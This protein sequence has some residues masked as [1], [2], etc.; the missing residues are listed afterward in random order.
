MEW[1]TWIE[2]AVFQIRMAHRLARITVALA[3]S[4]ELDE[5]MAGAVRN[6]LRS[7]SRDMV[8]EQGLNPVLKSWC[9][10][11]LTD[12]HSPPTHETAQRLQPLDD[13]IRADFADQLFERLEAWLDDVRPEVAGDSGSF[14]QDALTPEMLFGTGG[15]G[16]A[17]SESSA[18]TWGRQ[19]EEHLPVRWDVRVANWRRWVGILADLRNIRSS[20]LLSGLTDA[21]T[22]GEGNRSMV[23]ALLARMIPGRAAP[24]EESSAP[25][26]VTSWF[27]GTVVGYN[28]A[29]PWPPLVAWEMITFLERFV[30]ADIWKRVKSLL[31]PRTSTTKVTAG[32]LL[33]D[34]TDETKAF[35]EFLAT[36]A[37]GCGGLPALPDQGLAH[38]LNGLFPRNSGIHLRVESSPGGG[39]H[40]EIP[41]ASLHWDVS[42]SATGP[43]GRERIAII[44]IQPE[45]G[46]KTSGWRDAMTVRRGMWCTPQ[47]GGMN[48]LRSILNRLQGIVAD[49]DPW[50]GYG[51][52]FLTEDMAGAA[53]ID[54]WFLHGPE[55]DRKQRFRIFCENWFR[56]SM[57]REPEEAV[58]ARDVL[59]RVLR[60]FGVKVALV[61]GHSDSA[62]TERLVPSTA[63]SAARIGTR[64]LHVEVN[65]KK[66]ELTVSPV[67]LPVGPGESASLETLFRL[68]PFVRESRKQLPFLKAWREFDSAL[69]CVFAEPQIG[70]PAGER[71][72]LEHLSRFAIELFRTWVGEQSWFER[73]DP[74]G[75]PP[76]EPCDVE[77]LAALCRLMVQ[78]HPEIAD[79]FPFPV[80][81][82]SLLPDWQALANSQLRE[83]AGHESRLNAVVIDWDFSAAPGEIVRLST[84]SAAG[85]GQRFRLQI[86]VG[87]DTAWLAPWIALLEAAPLR[88]SSPLSALAREIRHIPFRV[89]GRKNSLLG[90]DPP[91]ASW[92][93]FEQ[94][95]QR[96]TDACDSRDREWFDRT[97][98][99]VVAGHCDSPDERWL[100][101]LLR[102]RLVPCWPP[103]IEDAAGRLSPESC[104]QKES[105]ANWTFDG[106]VPRGDLIPSASNRFAVTPEYARGQLS[107]GPRQ[108]GTLMDLAFRLVA[109]CGTCP[110][111]ADA[112]ERLA[113]ATLEAELGE[114]RLDP[115]SATRLLRTALAAPPEGTSTHDL[116]T[117]EWTL[118][119]WCTHA[120]C[121]LLPAALDGAYEEGPRARGTLAVCFDASPRGS[122]RILRYG[123]ARLDTDG[124]RTTLA[125]PELFRSAGSEPVGLAELRRML[126]AGGPAMAGLHR[127]LDDWPSAALDR[128]L[129]RA[130]IQMYVEMWTTDATRTAVAEP[131]YALE[132]LLAENWKIVRFEPQQTVEFP[133][134]WLENVSP[135]PAVR[136]I[137]RSIVRPGLRAGQQLKLQ[138]IV[139]AE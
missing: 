85:E 24:I 124:S 68:Q 134:E 123:L 117:I 129:E 82:D 39:A 1:P 35:L 94:S 56:L 70:Q 47:T 136:G 93:E 107:L 26:S 122:L 2:E 137:I 110:A 32:I 109:L 72:A 100:G 29:V 121:E 38:L 53:S 36:I 51:L 128:R 106:T 34:G 19:A 74:V 104:H 20:A 15:R 138:A 61:E 30:D 119:E 125:E 46:G 28:R 98:A 37:D 17:P 105:W 67:Y 41:V 58:A 31:E 96:F 73:G 116:E 11:A 8:W 130:A 108:E 89:A 95:V 76:I 14:F 45:N 101:E 10:Q 135:E 62:G 79:L 112:A 126:Q 65:G 63:V 114:A 4:P 57:L 83:T 71:R 118:R 99:A 7:L 5:A 55:S 33:A 3:A 16:T 49:E 132:R 91:C 88:P 127:K 50:L 133:E 113:D 9:R 27:L 12:P 66:S 42:E 115:E 59:L 111:L 75:E 86:G 78:R 48:E 81:P 69:I 80:A 60:K 90:D 22:A 131:R 77:L 44:R 52:G 40:L 43:F 54:E 25:V 13:E 102:Q 97:T 64:S 18:G 103:L 21:K 23:H 120:H 84:L 87:T 92:I 6:A 139:V